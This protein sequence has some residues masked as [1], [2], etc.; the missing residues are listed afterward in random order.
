MSAW[1]VTHVCSPPITIVLGEIMISTHDALVTNMADRTKTAPSAT[2]VFLILF[3]SRTAL[4]DVQ[5][6]CDRRPFVSVHQDHVFIKQNFTGNRFCACFRCYCA[7]SS[8]H[9]WASRR[10]PGLRGSC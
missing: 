2:D 5:E 1:T 3:F 9:D 10:P 4:R 6:T 8:Q 7:I